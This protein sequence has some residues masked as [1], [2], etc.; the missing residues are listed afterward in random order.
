MDI[1]LILAVSQ[2]SPAHGSSRCAHAGTTNGR[3][4]SDRKGDRPDPTDRLSDQELRPR[5][6]LGAGEGSSLVGAR[7]APRCLRF[8]ARLPGERTARSE[9]VCLQG[10]F[11][12][13]RTP[14]LSSKGD[15]KKWAKGPNQAPR[16]SSGVAQRCS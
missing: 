5:W 16:T 13:L 3:H 2:A 9:W 7:N 14:P 10:S 1:M 8:A 6:L 15:F 11:L 12:Y 4:C